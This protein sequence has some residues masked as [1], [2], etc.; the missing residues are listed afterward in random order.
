MLYD[1][2]PFQRP[3]DLCIRKA[4]GSIP[5]QRTRTPRQRT[6][7]RPGRVFTNYTQDIEGSE[8][9]LY[10]CLRKFGKIIPAFE[11][12]P[13]NTPLISVSHVCYSILDKVAGVE[14]EWV[15][16]LS[17]HLEF[18]NFRRRLKIFRFPSF[19]M[20][21]YRDLTSISK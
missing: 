20:L 2:E 8:Q 15:N 14:L 16:S 10:L 9:P 13:N 21:M 4:Q 17:Q 19:C 5:R 7:T 1:P 3:D 18:D 12:Y 11:E 6:R